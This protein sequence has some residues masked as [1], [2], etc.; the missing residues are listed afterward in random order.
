MSRQ[1]VSIPLLTS[2]IR[3]LLESD[4]LLSDLWVEGEVAETF[5][6]RS[7]HVYFTLRDTDSQLKCVLFRAQAQRLRSMPRAGDQIAAHGRIS[8]YERDGAYQLYVDLIQP[9]GL[10]ILALQLELLRQ[11][12]AAEGLFEPS[13]KRPIPTMPSCIGVV[14]SA[15][16]AVWHDIQ[17]VLRRRFPL[18]HLLLASTPVQGDNAPAGIVA[19]LQ[20][21]QDDGRADVIIV[22]RGGGSAEDLWCFND[23]RV[24]RAVFA[25]RVPVVSGVGHETDWTLI[26]DVADLRAPTPSAAAELCSPSIVDLAARIVD[27]QRRGTR[28]IVDQVADCRDSLAD[29]SSRLARLTPDKAVARQRINVKELNHRLGRLKH[30]MLDESR[31]QVNDHR[32]S[33]Q[34]IVKCHIDENLHA[35]QIEQ[36]RLVPDS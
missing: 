22:A 12:L 13:R 35:L 27:L 21:L 19:A 20:A 4:E 7:G 25:C 6:A 33:I 3:E 34:S 15:E 5:V 23:E 9:A 24:V 36:A 17:H 32:G 8:V 18:V 29:L 1:V 31:A 28:S 16:G 11:Q 26:D 2:Y 14:T 10:G 30:E